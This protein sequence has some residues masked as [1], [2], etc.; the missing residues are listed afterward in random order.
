VRFAY[1]F[2]S[3]CRSSL[4]LSWASTWLDHSS[5][6]LASKYLQTYSNRPLPSQTFQASPYQVLDLLQLGE[7]T[8]GDTA[9]FHTRSPECCPRKT[10]KRPSW[11]I[12]HRWRPRYYES[13]H[14]RGPALHRPQPEGDFGDRRDSWRVSQKVGHGREKDVSQVGL[15][16]HHRSKPGS[17]S[18]TSRNRIRPL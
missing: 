10:G 15:V 9:P 8:R 13:N 14:S 12:G 11:N 2:L 6:S 17:A 16:L 4:A 3:Q 1:S 18:D 7:W 5:K